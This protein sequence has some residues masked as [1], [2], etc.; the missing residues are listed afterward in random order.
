MRY[1]LAAVLVLVFSTSIHAVPSDIHEAARAGDME[2]IRNILS[3]DPQQLNAL[4]KVKFTPLDWACTRAQWDVARYLIEAG[5]DVKAVGFDGGSAMHRAC[6]YDKPEF[7]GL[8]MSKGADPE[9]QNQWERT[10]LHVATRRG[11]LK[12]V[13]LLLDRGVD[14]H[15]TTREGW[16]PLHVACMSG[17]D[18]IID[19]LIA[20]GASATITDHGGK[21]PADMR[22][23]RPDHVELDPAQL[24]EY[25]G[26]YLTDSDF[27][28]HIFVEDGVLHLVDFAVEELYSTGNDSFYCTREPWPV[29][30][31]RDENGAIGYVHVSFLRRTV[32]ANKKR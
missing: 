1:T 28:F 11:C 31:T 17:H 23:T 8:L 26:E 21:K 29:K 3:S 12:V 20:R 19:L 25:A 14:I 15:A 10:A 30:F 5:A 7:V 32:T 4:D 2:A 6:H 9:Q 27:A 18:E 16:T 24:E 22:I 13:K